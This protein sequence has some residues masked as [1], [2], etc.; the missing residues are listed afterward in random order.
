MEKKTTAR[1]REILEE[2]KKFKLN[3][4]I[5]PYMKRPGKVVHGSKGRWELS[6]SIKAS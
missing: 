1:D 2:L 4:K 3:K 5:L 6:S